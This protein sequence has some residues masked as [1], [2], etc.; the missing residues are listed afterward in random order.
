MNKRLICL[1]LAAVCILTSACLSSD[2]KFV[3]FKYRDGLLWNGAAAFESVDFIKPI[4]L[5]DVIGYVEDVVGTDKVYAMRNESREEWVYVRFTKRLT[6]YG[7][8]YKAVG[9]TNF[10]FET[11]GADKIE[12]QG[13]GAVQDKLIST[14]TDQKTVTTVA[15]IL[16][17]NDDIPLPGN[18]L[19]DE[20]V[21]LVFLS[22]DY[23]GL[24]YETVCVP[25]D[26]GNKYMTRLGD[27][28]SVFVIGDILDAY[29]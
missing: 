2:K 9:I 10:K 11:F 5:C 29:L 3:E 21:L 23:P 19:R 22:S 26:L 8:V 28:S 14:I 15:K 25:D 4:E 16:A 6:S 20:M 13:I 1:L 18:L 17:G 7:Q 12:V 27:G 24:K